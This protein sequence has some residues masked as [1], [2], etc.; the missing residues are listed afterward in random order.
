MTDFSRAWKSMTWSLISRP[1][2][3]ITGF[4]QA[5]QINDWFFMCDQM[6]NKSDWFGRVGKKPVI[7]LEINNWF[8]PGLPNQWLWF[9]SRPTKSMTGFFQAY[10]IN[11]WFDLVGLPNQWLVF[12]R[13]TKSMTGFFPTLPNQWLVFSRPTKSMTGFFQAYEINDWSFSSAIQVGKKS[14]TDFSCAIRP[15]KNQSLIFFQAY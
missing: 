1:T 4:F 12:S 9:F 6:L 15:G 13:P 5:Y 14:I 7:D 11:D 2:K 10:Q 8:F 3:S